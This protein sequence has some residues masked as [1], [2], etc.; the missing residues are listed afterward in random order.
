M[1]LLSPLQPAGSFRA[2]RPQNL[3]VPIAPELACSSHT[4]ARL[5]LCPPWPCSGLC[6]EQTDHRD[7]MAA[8][9][10]IHRPRKPLTPARIAAFLA[11]GFLLGL[12]LGYV[13]MG[14]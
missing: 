5:L 14:A 4:A 6:A 2:W 1:K 9:K 11:I 7:A 12:G 10:K 8:L 3:A 13:F